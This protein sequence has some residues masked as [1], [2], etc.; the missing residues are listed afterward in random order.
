MRHALLIA[1]SLL[2]QI[3]LVGRVLSAGTCCPGPAL[4]HH[5]DPVCAHTDATHI[6]KTLDPCSSS[7]DC[8]ADCGDPHHHHHHGK[9]IHAVPF[10]FC[11]EASSRLSPPLAVALQCKW[12]HQIPPE[13]PV[14]EQDEPPLI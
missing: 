3:G 12:Q 8:P 2:I 1:L 9:C 10:T 6:G 4:E 13:D 11:E 7:H 14:I 5:H